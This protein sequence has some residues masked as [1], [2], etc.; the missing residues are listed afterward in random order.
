ML[1]NCFL[2]YFA[3]KKTQKSK[4]PDVSMTR[5]IEDCTFEDGVNIFF[6]NL[7]FSEW[8]VSPHEVIN[9][10]NFPHS[11]P[12]LSQPFHQG[13]KFI[14]TLQMLWCDHLVLNHNQMFPSVYFIR[15]WNLL[16]LKS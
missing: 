15:D 14:L 2:K 1:I 12:I 4:L 5:P 3:F 10:H 9:I 16:D 11:K 6:L 8:T 7:V 13:F